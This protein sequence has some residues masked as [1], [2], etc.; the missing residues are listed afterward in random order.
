LAIL[1]A[2]RILSRLLAVLPLSVLFLALG[3]APAALHANPPAGAL[4][5]GRS[6]GQQRPM[7]IV[8][9]DL[10]YV[11][12]ADTAQQERNIA[13]LVARVRDLHVSAVFL[14]AFANPTG[15]T[16]VRA[17]YFPSRL[18]PMR[19]DLFA[20]V[21]TRLRSEAHVDV[22]AWMPV[23]AFD[24]GRGLSRVEAFD[25]E[26]GRS[27]VPAKGYLRLSPFDADARALIVRLY[28]ELARAGGF[29]GLF[30]SDDATLSDYEDSSAAAQDAYR[31]AG[32]PPS[33]GALR[34]DPALD[35][36]WIKLKEARLEGL[37]KDVIRHVG[38][39]RG[40]VRTARN[41]Y[42]RPV[43]SPAAVGEFAQAPA[44]FF[45]TYDYAVVMAMPCLE[46][47]PAGEAR[48]WIARLVAAA[49]QH[50]PGLARTVFELQSVDWR[51]PAED[52]ERR[53]TAATLV[54]E[55]NLLRDLGA[56][57]FGYY[58]DDFVLNHPDTESI[59]PA[60]SLQR[61]PPR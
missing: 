4:V 23:L 14:Q 11:H 27:R 28:G 60:L 59:R 19:A 21:A 8:Q 18:L 55:M 12:D 3:A 42:A 56:V 43:L 40:P 34:A 33:V 36:A 13:L 29:S 39:I 58:P 53:V 5:E 10:D 45:S 25:P 31:R 22:Y 54:D 15:D 32:L 7:R 35:A 46:D 26:T 44:H 20:R 57:N 50:D 51:R 49:A 2:G 41:L 24:F 52:P 9:V 30:F 37:I 17:V 1:S 6:A 48:A 16:V 47:I 61:S 38:A